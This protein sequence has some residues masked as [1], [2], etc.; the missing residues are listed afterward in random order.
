VLYNL[1]AI[2]TDVTSRLLDTVKAPTALLNAEVNQLKLLTA[3]LT[4]PAALQS[5][6]HLITSTLSGLANFED[7]N[8]KKMEGLSKLEFP[9]RQELSPLAGG[10][11]ASSGPLALRLPVSVTG[12]GVKVNLLSASGT[13]GTPLSL[14][15]LGVGGG[16][17]LQGIGGAAAPVTG[18]LQSA[19]N[20]TASAVNGVTS[21]ATTAVT[22][23]VQSLSGTAAKL[24][25][26][27]H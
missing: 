19:A 9:L 27:K 26:P 11:L 15:P 7:P 21:T 18:E 25:S 24:L 23:T 8:A 17:A 3:N 12:E 10:G 2:G 6:E 22:D 4:L 1:T 20:A 16:G 13:Y 5:H 14:D